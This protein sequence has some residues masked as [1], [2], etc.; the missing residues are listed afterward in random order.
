MQHYGYNEHQKV[1]ISQI[2]HGLMQNW[3]SNSGMQYINEGHLNII[4]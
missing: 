1:D 2:R 3:W 4:L